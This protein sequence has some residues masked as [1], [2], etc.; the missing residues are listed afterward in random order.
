MTRLRS[1]PEPAT[2][3]N[4]YAT[5]PELTSHLPD[6]LERLMRGDSPFSAAERELISGYVCGLNRCNYCCRAHVLAAAELGIGEDVFDAVMADLETAPIEDR[7]KPVL[8]YVRLLT[9]TPGDVTDADAA[10]VYAAGWDDTAMVHTIMIC[11]HF[12]FVTRIAQGAGLSGSEE[13]LADAA[14]RRAARGYT[15]SR[16]VVAELNATA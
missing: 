11:A 5:Y 13:E 14:Q 7:L 9:L 3:I 16:D 12:N 15:S 2:L 10:A 6:F 8:R 4:V 1:F